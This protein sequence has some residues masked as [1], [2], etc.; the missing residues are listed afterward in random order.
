[1]TMAEFLL[2]PAERPPLSNLGPNSPLPEMVGADVVW[3]GADGLCGAQRK[4]VPDL[5]AS[6]RPVDGAESRLAKELI[7]MTTS[8][9][10]AFLVIEGTP[11]WD[12]EGRLMDQHSTWTLKNHN[13]V[14]LSMQLAGVMVLSSRNQ[15]ETCRVIE[16]LYSWTQKKDHVSSLLSRPKAQTDGWGRMSDR[17]FAIHFLS[18][19]PG[20]GVE[21]AANIYDKLGNILT[22]TCTREELLTVDGIGKKTADGIIRALAPTQS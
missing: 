8:L 13:G 15:H 5:V 7:Q 19:L 14:L 10:H 18:A 9:T 16:H 20:V 12:T 11:Q 22:L 21:R 3:S 2:S 1:M 4:T 6:V 17:T